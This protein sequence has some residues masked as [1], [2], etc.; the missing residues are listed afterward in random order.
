MSD[1]KFLWQEEVNDGKYPL[2]QRRQRL[3]VD[4]IQGPEMVG[5]AVLWSR[6]DVTYVGLRNTAGVRT[7]VRVEA[8]GTG[9]PRN[10][11]YEAVRF[12]NR[13]AY[14][15]LFVDPVRGVDYKD[16]SDEGPDAD[17]FRAFAREAM[18]W[19]RGRK[20][21]PAPSPCP[22]PAGEAL[23]GGWYAEALPMGI[24]VRMGACRRHS[25]WYNGINDTGVNP[26]GISADEIATLLRM[27]EPE[28][29]VFSSWNGPGGDFLTMALAPK[30]S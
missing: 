22:P 15:E 11:D 18:T 28:A 12:W 13:D 3:V 26:H 9:M 21:G 14:R 16:I 20:S 6:D 4:G 23:W 19:Y 5:D 8:G 17:R 24:C 10:F 30:E 25:A 7:V 29:D 2:A 1:A 27:V